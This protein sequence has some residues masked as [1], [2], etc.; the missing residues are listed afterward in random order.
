LSDEE[1]TY[2]TIFTALRHPIRRRI[3][4]MLGEPLTFTAMLNRLGIESPHL[5]Y[6]LESLG[7]LI[8]KTES[9][10]YRLS[11]FG[12]AAVATMGWVEEAPK[13]EPQPILL[14]TTW[15]AVV[16]V[17]VIGVVVFAGLYSSQGQALSELSTNY[18]GLYMEYTGLSEAV[19][20]L[21]AEYNETL[22]NYDTVLA[23]YNELLEDVERALP[24]DLPAHV[25]ITRQ[26][27]W[28]DGTMSSCNLSGQD[29]ILF[30]ELRDAINRYDE[31]YSGPERSNTTFYIST[32]KANNT[33]GRQLV[34]FLEAKLVSARFYKSWH[35]DEYVSFYN[36]WH[37]EYVSDIR[38]QEKVYHVK[39]V[40]GEIGVYT[41]YVSPRLFPP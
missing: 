29:L 19:T 34:E 2:S 21:T 1:E 31:W 15:K 10:Q 30:P 37:Y 7:V 41:W 3:L 36:S 17:L 27:S 11:T 26:F 13:P 28:I 38:Y 39:I 9:G 22:G 25:G 6:H 18:D 23:E 24:S 35:D 8:A 4:R 32:F 14:T 12:R 20:Q 33:R 5:T 40:F 16:A